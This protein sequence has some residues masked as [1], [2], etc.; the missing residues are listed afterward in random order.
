MYRHLVRPLLFRINPERIHHLVA[1]GLQLTHVVPGAKQLMSSITSV[2]HP[3]LEREVFGLKFRNPVGVAA[4]F[5]KQ[6]T[7]YNQLAHLGFGFVEIGTITPLPQ[8]GNPK[9]RLFRLPA[10]QALINRMGFN[11]IGADQAVEN[12]KKRKTDIVIG[13][14]IGKNTVTPNHKAVDDYEICFRKLF[15]YVDYFVVNVSCPNISNLSELQDQDKLM[16][17]LNRLQQINHSHSKTKPILLKVS[18][19]LNDGQLEEVIDIV[20]QTQIDGVVAVNT[21]VTRHNLK[22]PDKRVEQIGNGG[23]SGLPLRDRATEVIRY[24][25]QKSGKSFPIIGAGGI[26]TPDDAIEKLQAGADLV[27]VYTGF[28]YEGPLIARNI[29][30]QLVLMDK[31]FKNEKK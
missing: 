21:T 28:V 7:L 9:P 10:D 26:F 3:S 2:T 30:R 12:L 8:S 27:Q 25:A 14:N 23:L 22:T 16:L 13:G 19:D 11:N 17:I 4:G 29:N 6:A 24:L 15:D 1:S 18:P 5:D 31:I 20:A